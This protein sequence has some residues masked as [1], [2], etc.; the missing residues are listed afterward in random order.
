MWNAIEKPSIRFS[1]SGSTASGV[2]SRPV[3]PVPPVV[4]MTSTPGSAIHR[5]TALRI[6][7]TSS[8]TISRAASLWPAAVRR[9][10]SVVPDLSSTS[11]RVSEIVN[12]AML[13]DTNFFDSSVEVMLFFPRFPDAV[14]RPLRCAASG[15]RSAPLQR[16]RPKRI[17]RLHRA[18]PIAGHEP[19]LP[20]R[21]G[22]VGE[23]IRHHPPGRLPLQRV[24]A[25]R[26]CRGQ[27]RID[28]AGF[29]EARTFLLFAVDPDTRQAIRLQLDPHLQRIGFRLAA[30]L[31]LQPRHTRQD[32]K[33]ILDMMAG[34]MGDD[35]GR[36]EFAGIAGTAVKPRLDLAE[37]SGVEKNLLFRRAIERPHRRL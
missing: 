9:S 16:R 21:G 7:S 30:G 37:K 19:L 31:L 10:D 24:V 11:A 20:L 35:I 13:R 32:A 33:Q 2:T 3:K 28:V 1:N 4:R 22:A 14:Q 29:K 23:R 15:A 12:T 18:L 26:R 34:F 25:D 36:G 6:A 27:R 8:V 17:T 5:L